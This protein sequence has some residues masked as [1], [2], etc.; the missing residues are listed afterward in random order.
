[1]K[2]ILKSVLTNILTI[3]ARL[4]LRIYRPYIIA[5]TGNVGKTSTKDAIFSVI[6]TRYHARSSEKSYNSEIGVP[7]TIL[8][9]PNG[10]SSPLVWMYNIIR[11]ARLILVRKPYPEYL[12][13]EVGAD[14][15]G[16]IASITRWLRPHITVLTRMSSVPVHVEYFDNPEEV[17]A[18]KMHLAKALRKN[19]TIVVN[20]DDEMFMREVT[21][22]ASKKVTYGRATDSV[23]CIK[24]TG[25]IYDDRELRAPIGESAEII[26]PHES[27]N[28]EISG[29]LGEHLVYPFAGATAVAHA[30][31]MDKIDWQKVMS[32]YNAPRG[33][34][35]IIS[36]REHSTIIDD[37]YNSSPLAL[38]EA[39][40]TL[41]NVITKGRKIAVLGDMK[42][43]GPYTR[44]EHEKAGVMVA[45]I[46]HTLVAVGEYSRDIA[47][48]ASH[49]TLAKNRV[50]WFPTSVEAG[51]FLS[52]FIRAGDIILVKG[53]QSMRME[54][55]ILPILDKNLDPKDVL[56]RQEDEWQKR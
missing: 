53:S 39:L 55:A 3:E 15:P 24:N 12:V 7:L 26:T 8:G 27:Y 1:M 51:E 47:H 4:V 10:W 29:S 41:D 56:V 50:H 44:R 46:A 30:L 54:K 19:G 49:T 23:V 22:I 11:G 17:L 21:K 20:A 9:C 37:T 33:R 36:G 48:S 18:E 38:E 28:I 5:V 16:D 34:M 2:K 45:R 42:E 25:I 13:L 35:R 32:Q 40:R 31:G 6:S 14:H 43:L 52:D